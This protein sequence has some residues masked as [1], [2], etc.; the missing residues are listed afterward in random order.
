MTVE[1]LQ[2]KRADVIVAGGLILEVAMQSL[3]AESIT[4]SDRG[5]RWGVLAHHFGRET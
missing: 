5:L 2:P 4:V 3:G 1:G